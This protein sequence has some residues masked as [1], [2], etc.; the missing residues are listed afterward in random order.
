MGQCLTEAPPSREPVTLDGPERGCPDKFVGC[1]DVDN[2]LRLESNERGS[3]RWQQ[4]AWTRCGPPP[5][6]PDAGR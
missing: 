6:S 2:A 5:P 3:R 4:E 1:I